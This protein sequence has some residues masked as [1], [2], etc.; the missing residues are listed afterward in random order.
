M[1]SSLLNLQH[2]EQCMEHSRY[3]INVCLVN[4]LIQGYLEKTVFYQKE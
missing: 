4:E 1:S 2:L 3:S